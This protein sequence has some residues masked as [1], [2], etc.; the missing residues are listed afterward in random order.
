MEIK[1]LSK[2]SQERME[3]NGWGR[4]SVRDDETPADTVARY[5]GMGYEAKAYRVTTYVKG[6]YHYIVYIKR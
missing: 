1:T 5:A 3:A 2:A 6:Y 4:R